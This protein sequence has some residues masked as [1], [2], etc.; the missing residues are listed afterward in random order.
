MGKLLWKW[1]GGHFMNQGV[2]FGRLSEAIGMG[3][4]GR[5]ALVFTSS[6]DECVC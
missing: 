1:E 4:F 5:S 6:A 3:V 2:T